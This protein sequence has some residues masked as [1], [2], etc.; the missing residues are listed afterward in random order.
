MLWTEKVT[1]HQSLIKQPLSWIK[2]TKLLYYRQLDFEI[3]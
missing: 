3:K 2:C 1:Y